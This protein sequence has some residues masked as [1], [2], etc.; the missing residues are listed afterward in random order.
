MVWAI[1]DSAVIRYSESVME[2]GF[3]LYAGMFVVHVG[4]DTTWDCFFVFFA[5]PVG[6]IQI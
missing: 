2:H 6:G 4:C 5:Q 1:C 3:I